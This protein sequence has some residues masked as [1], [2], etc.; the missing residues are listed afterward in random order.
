M[1][2]GLYAT[3]FL[4]CLGIALLFFLNVYSLEYVGYLHKITQGLFTELPSFPASST[5]PPYR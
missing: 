3:F 5:S 2:S 1:Q 4:T